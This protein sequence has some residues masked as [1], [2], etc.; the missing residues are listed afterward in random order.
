MRKNNKTE[1]RRNSNKKR[2]LRN[3]NSNRTL[4]KIM[5]CWQFL[6][7]YSITN[8]IYVFVLSSLSCNLNNYTYDEQMRRWK[9]KENHSSLFYQVK[10]N[11]NP[12]VQETVMR[13]IQ[14]FEGIRT[15]WMS[16]DMLEHYFCQLFFLLVLFFFHY[17]KIS[18]YITLAHLFLLKFNQRFVLLFVFWT[19][20]CSFHIIGVRT[21][22]KYFFI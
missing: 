1:I 9:K 14:V 11:L 17:S 22:K 7:W 10:K 12:D 15:C 19:R 3:H 8:L 5:A 21:K 20:M 16:F 18:L 13:L 2:K 6:T 4:N